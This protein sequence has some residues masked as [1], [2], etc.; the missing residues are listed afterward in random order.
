V[1]KLFVIQFIVERG[2]RAHLNS[3][4]TARNAVRFATQFGAMI[5]KGDVT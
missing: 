4:G 5:I 3:S 1:N 2:W